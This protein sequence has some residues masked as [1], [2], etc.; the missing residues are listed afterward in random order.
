MQNAIALTVEERYKSQIRDMQKNF[1][2]VL[3][4]NTSKKRELESEIKQLSEKLQNEQKSK[5]SDQTALGRQLAVALENETKFKNIASQ[6]AEETEQKVKDITLKFDE[7]KGVYKNK[8][9]DLENKLREYE[10]KRNILAVDIVKE[11][12]MFDKD[13]ESMRN[14]VEKLNERLQSIE[15]NYV[16]LTNENKELT[17]DNQRMKRDLKGSKFGSI[18]VPKG[19]RYSSGNKEN[20][21]THS[22]GSLDRTY[23]QLDMLNIETMSKTKFSSKLSQKSVEDDTTSNVS[24]L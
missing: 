1:S 5:F 9:I 17:K 18:Y 20:I 3:E 16:K 23:D 24:N 22:N 15:R 7:D 19:N 2:T 6:L 12:T 8:I 11:K 10:T 14:D 4:E 21:R 13:K